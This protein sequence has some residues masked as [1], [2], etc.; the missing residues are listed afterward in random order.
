[1]LAKFHHQL[2]NLVS[3]FNSSPEENFPI[4]GQASVSFVEEPCEIFVILSHSPHELRE[5]LF[6]GGYD[7]I[8]EI[9]QPAR[10]GHAECCELGYCRVTLWCQ[11]DG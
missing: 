2:P 5:L 8:R 7:V 3:A 6:D 10:L 4:S 9:R 1:M 11:D